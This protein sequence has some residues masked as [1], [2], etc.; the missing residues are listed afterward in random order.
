MKLSRVVLLASLLSS[1]GSAL[2][3]TTTNIPPTVT[4][5]S[6]TNGS[7]FT[8]PADIFLLAN[9]IDRDGE[10]YEVSFFANEHYIGGVTNPPPD[11]SP[12]PPWRLQWNGVAAGQYYLR[13]RAVDKAEGIGWSSVVRVEVRG[14]NQPPT[15][16]VVNVVASD[17]DAAETGVLTWIQSGSFRFTRSGSISNAL[18]VHFSIGGTAENGVDY[19]YLSNSITFQPGREA[20]ELRVYP[21]DDA[22]IEPTETVVV[23]LIDPLCAAMMPPP[24][25]CYRVGSSPAVTVNI[26]DAVIESN[27]PPV[28]RIVSPTNESRFPM[29]AN[30]RIHADAF[31]N[32]RYLDTVEFFANNQNLGIVTNNPFSL[33]PY[34]GYSVIWSNA[35]AGEYR[36]TAKASDNFGLMTTSAPVRIVV[37][38]FSIS[39]VPPMVRITAPTNGAAFPAEADITV[40][41]VTIDPD[42]YAPFVELFADGAKIGEELITFVMAPPDGT[43]IHFSFTWSNVVAGAHTLAARGTDDDGATR[44]SEPVRIYVGTNKPPPPPVTTV[45]TIET[46]DSIATEPSPVEDTILPDNAVLRV[47]RSG[48]TNEALTVFYRTGGSASNGVDYAGLSGEV[49]I[50]AGA[51]SANLVIEAA[52]D[53]LI[54][55]SETVVVELLLPPC[56][57]IVPPPPGC[58][59]VG[60]P[61]RATAYI[62]DNDFAP[63]N[64]PPS[65][66]ITAPTSGTSFP[67]GSAIHIE[68]T[69]VDLDGYAPMIEFFADGR[70]IGEELITFVQPPTN[71]TPIH[72]S[73]VWSNVV[74][75]AHTLAARATDDD[76]AQRFSEPVYILVGTNQPPPPPPTNV[77]VSIVAIDAY[78]SEGPWT[79]LWT[80]PDGTRG[81]NVAVF[82]V[83]REGPTNEAVTVRYHVGGTASNGVD[84]VELPGEVTIPAGARGARITVLPLEDGLIE[85]NETVVLELAPAGGEPPSYILGLSRRAAAVIADNEERPRC[86]RLAGG[87]YHLCLPGI[88]GETYR[89]ESSSDLVHWTTLCT[90]V[91]VDG[92]VHV[93]DADADGLPHRFYRAVPDATAS[94]E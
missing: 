23:R 2:A 1:L 61:A 25:G 76:G 65:V 73:F 68:A 6:P 87:L 59:T 24:P 16:P 52:D 46:V 82:G 54:E 44:W 39:N 22:L 94:M 63:S 50:P 48:E 11:A 89:I 81:T 30:I 42:G 92:A 49:L 45:V 91:V 34:A 20:A 36:L 17:S 64:R 71:G 60:L 21:L 32:D 28:V 43:P 62:R 8:A 93:V 77:V 33:A 15:L 14:T 5:V 9:A 12:L 58:Y 86:V 74:A 66:R 70:K 75:G 90:T 19:R 31:D 85:G 57:A 40:N 10:V 47:R 84:Y 56:L 4:I 79:N 29:G 41:V 27:R 38:D 67:S 88:N 78:A 51:R 72:F 35:P 37:G 53:L 83:R 80:T 26:R 7:V 18:T 69:T 13:A 55:G 3:Q